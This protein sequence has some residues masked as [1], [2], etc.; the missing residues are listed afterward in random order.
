M[1]SRVV[2]VAVTV[3]AGGEALSVAVAKLAARVASNVEV[4]VYYFEWVVV[5]Q[6]ALR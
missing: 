1:A 6:V 4:L 3:C 2:V 5:L